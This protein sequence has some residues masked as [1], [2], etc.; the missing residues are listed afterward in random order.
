ME[1]KFIDGF[2][3]ENENLEK[4]ATRI[5]IKNTNYRI[6]IISTKG[7]FVARVRGRTLKEDKSIYVGPW[8]DNSTILTINE[9]EAFEKDKKPWQYTIQYADEGFRSD[10]VTFYDGTGKERQ[11]LTRSNTKGQHL[12][13]AE[14][15]YDFHGRP[16]IQ[17]LL[18]PLKPKEKINIYGRSSEKFKKRNKWAN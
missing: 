6:P 4:N 8:S 3:S 17:S 10:V 13:A 1:W 9:S 5:N 15:Y 18:T 12:I 11:S 14:K 16:V 7:K 2:S